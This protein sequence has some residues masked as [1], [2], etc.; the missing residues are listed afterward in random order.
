MKNSIIVSFVD[1]ITTR[2]KCHKTTCLFHTYTTSIDL[3]CW[4]CSVWTL[5]R[6]FLFHSSPLS[7][8]HFLCVPIF[9]KKTNLV[10]WKSSDQS[11]AFQ[12][13][14]ERNFHLIE[15][16]LLLYIYSECFHWFTHFVRSFPHCSFPFLS[17]CLKSNV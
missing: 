16:L 8:L 7:F 4:V 12:L 3:H 11:R 15:S 13:F 6:S 2:R 17:S 14:D 9:K 1:W 5:P 10:L